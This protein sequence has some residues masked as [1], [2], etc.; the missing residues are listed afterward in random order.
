MIVPGKGFRRVDVFCQRKVRDPLLHTRLIVVDVPSPAQVRP[1]HP[2]QFSSETFK[3]FARA[4]PSPLGLML[5][6]EMQI[7]GAWLVWISTWLP[8]NMGGQLITLHI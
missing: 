4:I 6:L 1:H 5:G 8:T 2:P 3:A 7:V